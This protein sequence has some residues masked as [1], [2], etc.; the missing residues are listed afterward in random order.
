MGLISRRRQWLQKFTRPKSAPFAKRLK[1]PLHLEMCSAHIAPI[2]RCIGAYQRPPVYDVNLLIYA[3]Y[4]VARN[5]NVEKAKS[6]LRNTLDWRVNFK[7]DDITGASVYEAGKAGKVFVSGI[8]I[9]G[10]PVLYMRPGTHF[11]AVDLLFDEI[12]N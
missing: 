5:G 9:F 6:L 12:S 2:S 8:D 10:R 1:R 7:V 4:L 11:V 3:R